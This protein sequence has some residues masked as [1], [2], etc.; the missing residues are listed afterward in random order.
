METRIIEVE[1]FTVR[2]YELKGPLSEIPGIWDVLNEEIAK[3]G[4]VAEESFGLCLAIQGGE[5]HYLAGVKSNLAE[6]FP[7][8]EEAVV[9]AGKFIVAKV[10]GGVSEIST[11]F[12]ALL[13]MDGIR[14]RNSYGLER[15][16]HPKGSEGYTIEVWMPVE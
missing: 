7:N 8:T 9:P 2:G 3:S 12:N 16:I 15:Y 1:A 14:L 10:E 13:Q 6:G 4:I 5:I 11:A